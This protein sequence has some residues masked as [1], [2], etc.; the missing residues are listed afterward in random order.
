[1]KE[2]SEQEKQ[3]EKVDN[4]MNG[5]KTTTSPAML[6]REDEQRRILVH[7]MNVTAT[8]DIKPVVK[9]LNSIQGT[10]GR[11]RRNHENTHEI[12]KENH[13]E[14]VSVKRE[15]KELKSEVLDIAF[16]V[17]KST[18]TQL[19]SGV[20]LSEFFPVQ[21]AQQLEDFMDRNHPQW[22]ERKKE[23]HHFLFNCVTDNKKHFSKGL[24]KTLFSR[25]YMMTVKWPSFG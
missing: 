9:V 8:D 21:K 5:T 22:E 12:V 4:L 7:E 25:Q 6:D 2:A 23:F 16:H 24:L 14:I 13:G 1:M 10:M 3:K 18:F 19:M 11:V 20:D 17:K 15:I